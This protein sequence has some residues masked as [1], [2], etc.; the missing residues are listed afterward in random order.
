[1]DYFQIN[2]AGI[3]RTMATTTLTS[4]QLQQLANSRS[5]LPPA[6]QTALRGVGINAQ[7]QRTTTQLI[8][9]PAPTSGTVVA[10]ATAVPAVGSSPTQGVH[11]AAMLR[12][13]QQHSTQQRQ[14]H[15]ATIALQR[16]IGIGVPSTG[17][18]TIAPTLTATSSP[19][20]LLAGTTAT[21]SATPIALAVANQQQPTVARGGIVTPHGTIRT[22][23]TGATSGASTIGGH[24]II[25][26]QASSQ[27]TNSGTSALNTGSTSVHAVHATRQQIVVAT[28][29]AAGH[30]GTPGVSVANNATGVVTPV[31]SSGSGTGLTRQIVVTHAGGNAA[32]TA[33]GLRSGQILQV[34]GQ[35]GQQHQIVVSQSGQII[36]NPSNGS[37][38]K[39]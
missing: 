3:P 22:A 17:S 5:M 26:T 31:S 1:M 35:G 15:T 11:T 2:L 32:A 6:L 25:M 29:Q 38:T 12:P 10:G 4:Q 7:G 27:A 13:Q 14:P 20:Q 21:G 36:L 19:Q 34:T 39:Q 24:Q 33:A 30:S 8:A 23:V 28:T 18:G 9:R 37:G 16:P